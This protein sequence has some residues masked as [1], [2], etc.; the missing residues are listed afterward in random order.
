M[1]K[2]ECASEDIEDIK[3]QLVIKQQDV[4]TLQTEN[5]KLRRIIKL[6]SEF[7]Y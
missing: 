5:S 3:K 4:Y 1:E 2:I 6:L 7:I